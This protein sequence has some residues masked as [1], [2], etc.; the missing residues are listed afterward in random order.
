MMEGSHGSLFDASAQPVAGNA[1]NWLGQ[2][3]AGKLATPL[4][5]VATAILGLLM[6]SR[7]ASKNAA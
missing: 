1:G 2:L 3:L 6:L 4:C 7:G 5:I